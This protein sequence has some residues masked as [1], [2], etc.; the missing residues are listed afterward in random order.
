MIV[1][2]WIGIVLFGLALVV[3][4]IG[5]M[6]PR[7]AIVNRQIE[8]SAKQE[9]IFPY[10]NDLRKFVDHWSPWTEKDPNMQM[11][12]SGPEEGEGAVY[13]WKGDPKKVGYGT[14]RIIKVESPSKVISLLSFGGRG[15]AEV[16]ISIK[17]LDNGNCE[18][19][20][21]FVAD[22]KM[23]PMG[24]IFGKMMDKFLGPDFELGLKKLKEVCENAGNM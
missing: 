4:I 19:S 12:F 16:T 5:F 7:M 10:A 18:V 1:L 23:N 13:N 22:N 6:M 8:I 15:D 11:E 21:G 17:S 24:R 14:M 3:V 2:A 20:W 9:T